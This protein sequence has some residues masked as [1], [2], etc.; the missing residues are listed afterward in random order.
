MRR[1]LLF[2]SLL[3]YM[4]GFSQERKVLN[5]A[6]FLRTNP[7]SYIEKDAGIMLGVSYRWNERFAFVFDPMFIFYN[8]YP[9]FNDPMEKKRGI[10]IR[11]DFR[12]YPG[13]TYSWKRL[14]IAPELHFKAMKEKRWETFG[15]DCVSGNCAYYTFS[16]F[17]EEVIE[18]GISFKSGIEV[19]SDNQR[20]AVEL[21]VGLGFKYLNFKEKNIPVGGSFTNP[22]DHDVLFSAHRPGQAYPIVPGGLK[23][24]YRI[25]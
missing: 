4:V 3:A 9:E 5:K 16:S 13:N 8:P 7:T 17:T 6:W 20:W 14:F 21:F 22:P 1:L 25:K 12:Y 15:I 10:K 18:Y 23:F 2:T 11:S 19:V 24:G